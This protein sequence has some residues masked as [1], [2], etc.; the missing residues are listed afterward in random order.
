MPA[1]TQTAH[2]PIARGCRGQRGWGAG[3][4]LLVL[5]LLP[6][7]PAVDASGSNTLQVTAVVL[8]KN[9]CRFNSTASALNFGSI[10][11]T[12]P[13]PVTASMVLVYRCNGSDPVATWSVSSDSGLHEL[14]PGQYRMQH[15]ALANYLP[16]TLAFPAS[17]SAP[18]NTNLNM[19]ITGTVY[20]ADFS[21]AIAGA[22]SDTVVLSILP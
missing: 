8:S 18:R 2:V 1:R 16:Y 10:N 21:A 13:A 6:G 20:P 19:T 15:S 9:T 4:G 5:T 12:N 17:G 7:V 11:P 3:A 22:Y 14:G